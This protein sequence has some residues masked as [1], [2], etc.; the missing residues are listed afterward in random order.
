M[1]KKEKLLQQIEKVTNDEKRLIPL[2]NRHISTSLFFSG[3]RDADRKKTIEQF[4]RMVVAHTK[5][6]EYLKGIVDEV[7]KGKSDVY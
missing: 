4:Q 6:T 3:L 5:H 1:I 7:K 2:L